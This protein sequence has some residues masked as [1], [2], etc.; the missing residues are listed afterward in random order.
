MRVLFAFSVGVYWHFIL[1]H[2][3][4]GTDYRPSP[5]FSICTLSISSP[6][7]FLFSLHLIF[8][9]RTT[10]AALLQSLALMHTSDPPDTLSGLLQCTSMQ[11]LFQTHLALALSLT[12]LSLFGPFSFTW[13]PHDSSMSRFICSASFFLRLCIIPPL[14][15][16]SSTACRPNVSLIFPLSIWHKMRA[17]D[18]VV[19]HSLVFNS[20]E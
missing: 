17:C 14:P 4:S 8:Y 18:R 19:S 1:H 5:K 6:R 3:S 16:Y 15:F 7:S 9:S 2:L 20:R 10:A 13:S 11:K 12:S